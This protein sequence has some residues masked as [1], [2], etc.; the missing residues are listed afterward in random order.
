MKDSVFELKK[1]MMDWLQ[2]N[3]VWIKWGDLD[4]VETSVFGRM[5]AA[6]DTMV[7]RPALKNRLY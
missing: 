1:K 5:L 2:T 4:S 7:F 3:R 6:H